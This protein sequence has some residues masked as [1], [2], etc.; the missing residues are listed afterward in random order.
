VKRLYT[1]KN[2]T[3]SQFILYLSIEKSPDSVILLPRRVYQLEITFEEFSF[4]K[5]NY[6]GNLYLTSTNPF[7]MNYIV[8]ETFVVPKGNI[9]LELLVWYG[10]A[11][12][13]ESTLLTL[14]FSSTSHTLDFGSA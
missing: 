10:D 11:W 13:N 14:D 1:I 9:E 4:I 6:L 7:V 5:S 12:V 8:P 3:N 2:I